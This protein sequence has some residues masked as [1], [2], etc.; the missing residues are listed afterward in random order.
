MDAFCFIL[1]HCVKE[2]L[3]IPLKYQ[4]TKLKTFATWSHKILWVLDALPVL[5]WL[6]IVITSV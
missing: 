5:Y 4:D 3:W 1:I 2:N 6:I